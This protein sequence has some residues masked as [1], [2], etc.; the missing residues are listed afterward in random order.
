VYDDIRWAHKM[1]ISSSQQSLAVARAHALVGDAYD[2]PA[3]IGFALEVLKLRSG[4]ELAPVFRADS[5]RVCSALVYDCQMYANLPYDWSRLHLNPGQDP[6]LV[7]PGMLLDYG[8]RM[9]WM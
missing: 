4:K 8:T 2:Y 9:E 6:N 5:W 7:S 1:P 3:Y